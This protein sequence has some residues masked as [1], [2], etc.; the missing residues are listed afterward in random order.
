MA[1]LERLGRS[2]ET[3]DGEA[4]SAGGGRVLMLSPRAG[5][6]YVLV[7]DEAGATRELS[8]LPLVAQAPAGTKVIY[9]FLDGELLTSCP[10]DGRVEWTM[11]RGT[12]VMVAS[13]DTGATAVARFR[14]LHPPGAVVQAAR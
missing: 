2:G 5:G 6:E 4:A 13:C 1:S 14:V 12:H 7:P 3:A 8:R 11:E 10:P 9:W